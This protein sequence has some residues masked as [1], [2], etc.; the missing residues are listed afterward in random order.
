MSRARVTV[1]GSGRLGIGLPP[2]SGS[3]P[4]PYSESSRLCQPEPGT[5]LG[6]ESPESAL[7]RALHCLTS[8]SRVT[9]AGAAA[10]PSLLPRTGFKFVS[11]RPSQPD[12]DFKF[13]ISAGRLVSV[14]SRPSQPWP[15]LGFESPSISIRS[16]AR[17]TG[18]PARGLRLVQQAG[19]RRLRLTGARLEVIHH[20]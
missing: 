18:S 11:G 2:A 4:G 3:S 16:V 12:S 15:Y 20:R 8:G 13:R 17:V 1:S 19:R 10:P 6:S 9:V 5:C 14:S 7:R